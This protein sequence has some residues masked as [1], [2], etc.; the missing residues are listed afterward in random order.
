MKIDHKESYKEF[1][2]QFMIDSNIDDYWGSRDM[3]K[4]IVKP[5]TLTSIKNNLF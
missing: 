5:F 4:D 2:E 1:G 3:L